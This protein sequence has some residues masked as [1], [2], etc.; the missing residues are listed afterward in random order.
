MDSQTVEI[1][2]VFKRMAAAILDVYDLCADVAHRER[3]RRTVLDQTE[4]ARRRVEES[5]ND[6]RQDD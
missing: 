2:R 6:V 5:L 1:S 3:M 4:L